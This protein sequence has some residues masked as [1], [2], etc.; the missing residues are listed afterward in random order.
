ML[1][2][3]L[4]RHLVLDVSCSSCAESHPVPLDLIEESQHLL[5]TLGPCSGMASYECPAPYFAGL[6][7]RD[8]ISQLRA[9]LAAFESEVRRGGARVAWA[10]P[11]DD[12]LRCDALL[13]SSSVARRRAPAASDR[14]AVELDRALA[15]WDDDGGAQDGRRPA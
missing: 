4:S 5:D 8:A 1:S 11:G 3:Q 12:R 14:E 15:R 13:R 10:D 2:T 9:A 6:A 7:P